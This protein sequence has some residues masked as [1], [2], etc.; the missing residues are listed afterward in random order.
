MLLFSVD[1]TT[2]LNFLLPTE[3]EKNRLQK[4]LIIGP[5][6]FF[7]NANQPKSQFLFHKNLPPRDFSIITLNVAKVKIA[8]FQY[9]SSP[10][11]CLH[12]VLICPI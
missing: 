3:M 7:S 12:P 9:D 10:N 2:F 6:F 5:N 1:A 11:D 8:A 4:L